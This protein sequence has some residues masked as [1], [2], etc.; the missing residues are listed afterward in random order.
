MASREDETFQWALDQARQDARAATDANP[1]PQPGRNIC[2]AIEV[3]RRQGGGEAQW[4]LAMQ[5]THEPPKALAPSAPDPDCRPEA[6]PSEMTAA[7]AEELGLETALT[8]RELASRWRDF[9]WRNHPDRLPSNARG[10]AGARAAI[11]NALYDEARRK[12]AT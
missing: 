6:F 7:I 11:A 1:P 10:R 4:S 9:L 2:A 8:S 5:W 3:G 12:L